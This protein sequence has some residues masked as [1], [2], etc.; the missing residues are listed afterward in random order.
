MIR[1]C[2]EHDFDEIWAVINDGSTAYRGI[3]PADCWSEPYMTR[4]KLRHEM[5]DG[6]VFWAAEE[7]GSIQAVMGVQDVLDVTLIRHAYVRTSKRRHGLGATLLQHLQSLATR[8]VFI[9]TWADAT[10]AIRFYE[11]H[12]YRLVPAE[13]K[14]QLLRRYWNVSAR[15]IETSVVLSNREVGPNAYDHSS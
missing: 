8:R 7:D 11:K 15:Q 14:D 3:I 13:Q 12:G 2:N 1:A 4:E 6:V 9:G 5:L 10:W